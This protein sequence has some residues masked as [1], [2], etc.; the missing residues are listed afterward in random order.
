MVMFPI[1]QDEEI[2]NW[3]EEIN[4]QGPGITNKS[5]EKSIKNAPEKVKNTP[6]Y[7]YML[8]WLDGKTVINL[9]STK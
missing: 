8:G 1:Y 3:I 6:D 4:M 5:L 9:E 7:F 2:N